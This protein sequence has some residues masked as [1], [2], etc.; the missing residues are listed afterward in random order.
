MNEIYVHEDKIDQI[1]SPLCISGPR[2]KYNP[3]ECIIATCEKGG[4]LWI[5]ST[6]IL[7]LLGHRRF[8]GSICV[9]TYEQCSI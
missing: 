7:T 3:P 4:V 8:L 5:D 1:S 2:S 9:H 6:H